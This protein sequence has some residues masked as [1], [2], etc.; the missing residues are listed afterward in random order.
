MKRVTWFGVG[1]ATGASA[2]VAATKRVRRTAEQLKPANMARSVAGRA[3]SRGSDL[4][5]ALREGRVEMR[6]KER[7]LKQRRDAPDPSLPGL[8]GPAPAGTTINYIVL[9]AREHPDVA[10]MVDELRAP[11]AGPRRR[12]RRSR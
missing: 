4:V 2:A 9:D 5:D 11:G 6:T 8:D 1:A 3:R 7:E 12:S 10:R